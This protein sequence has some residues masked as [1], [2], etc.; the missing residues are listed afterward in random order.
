MRTFQKLF[1]VKTGLQIFPEKSVEE[2][3][4]LK[5]EDCVKGGLRY[6]YFCDY[7]FK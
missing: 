5:N 2:N 6:G 1:N 3:F 4:R 7:V